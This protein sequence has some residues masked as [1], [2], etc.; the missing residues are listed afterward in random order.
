MIDFVINAVCYKTWIE[1]EANFHT[2]GSLNVW[3]WMYQAYRSSCPITTF[4]GI[5]HS[6]P[7]KNEYMK[8]SEIGFTNFC[9]LM[10]QE[11][12]WIQDAVKDF[13]MPLYDLIMDIHEEYEGNMMFGDI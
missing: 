5:S 3:K 1:I 4:N 12:K 2:R 7:W 10:E 9:N 8:K 13:N 11:V 6:I